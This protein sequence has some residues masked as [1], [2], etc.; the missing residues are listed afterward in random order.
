MNDERS[1][2]YVVNTTYAARML[3]DP[4]SHPM[5]LPFFGEP[6]L[7]TNAARVA[8][9]SASTMLAAVRRFVKA[10]VLIVAGKK[11]VRGRALHLYQTPA[12]NFI[13]PMNFAEDFVVNPERFWHEAYL[14]AFTHKLLDYHYNVE[15]IGA[16]ISQPLTRDIAITGVIGKT[17]RD[18]N[19]GDGGP[20]VFFDWRAFELGD[21][22]ADELRQELQEIIKKY[23]ARQ[24]TGGRTHIVGTHMVP[25]YP[26]EQFQRRVVNTPLDTGE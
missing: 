12:P 23:E 24:V 6:E 3:L 2:N 15:P 5:L 19:P 22:D 25:A 7:V 18:Y 20:E 1:T 21:A 16:K 4:K 8:K 17:W 13:I 9:V 14:Q 11:I 10:G 26:I